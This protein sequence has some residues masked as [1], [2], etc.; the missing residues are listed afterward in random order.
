MSES[1]TTKLVLLNLKGY[2][3]I[4]ILSPI[5]RTTRQ[6]IKYRKKQKQQN[7]QHSSNHQSKEGK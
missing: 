3:I 4:H 7:P 5:A 1:T 6:A 2:K